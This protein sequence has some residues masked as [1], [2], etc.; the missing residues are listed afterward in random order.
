MDSYIFSLT[1]NHFGAKFF[2][3]VFIFQSKYKNII[4]ITNTFS[5][6][7]KTKHAKILHRLVLYTGL[8]YTGLNTNKPKYA[9]TQNKIP[10][11]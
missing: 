8:F 5:L 10:D 9:H 7:Q 6:L 3:T 11:F 2:T 1:I 4:L